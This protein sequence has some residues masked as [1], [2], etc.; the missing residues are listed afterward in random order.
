M[1]A[2]T[3]AG[4]LRTALVVAMV[5][6][7]SS[8]G[9][10]K[11]PAP[12]GPPLPAAS[13]E[14]DVVMSEYAFAY[15]PPAQAGRVIFRVRNAGQ[16][17]HDLNLLPLGED[18]PPIDAQLR[19]TTRRALA[20]FAELSPR[21]PGASG[22]FAVDLVAGRRYALICFVRDADGLPHGLK[23]MTSEFRAGGGEPPSGA[24]P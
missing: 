21:A 9:P 18:V 16:V 7:T 10:D 15:A 24:G 20:P 22:V 11:A 2:G 19:G 5:A 6:A 13:P 23:G 14:L 17:P 8:C 4:N 3:K 1:T 12:P